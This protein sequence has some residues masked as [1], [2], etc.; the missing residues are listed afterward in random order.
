MNSANKVAFHEELKF[1]CTFY[2]RY[3]KE[4][5]LKLHL[6]ILTIT[7]SLPQSNEHNFHSIVE[8]IRKLSPAQRALMAEVCPLISM[9]LVMPA[10]NAISE[11]SFSALKWVKTYFASYY[12]SEKD[13]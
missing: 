12:D 2:H 7:L 13:Q 1:V 3:F 9:I 6:D 5:Q 8:F 11:Q 4:E 10:T